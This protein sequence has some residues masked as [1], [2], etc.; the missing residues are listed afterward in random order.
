M[1][2]FKKKPSIGRC[3]WVKGEAGQT[4]LPAFGSVLWDHRSP[5][6]PDLHCLGRP[7][8]HPAARQHLFQLLR[9]V[10][11]TERESDMSD[12]GIKHQSVL[13]FQSESFEVARIF[14]EAEAR[15]VGSLLQ[16][17]SEALQTVITHRVTVSSLKHLSISYH[18]HSCMCLYAHWSAF[19]YVGDNLRQDLLPPV[20]GKCH[21]IQVRDVQ[22][23]HH[24]FKWCRLD[25]SRAN[26]HRS[27]LFKPTLS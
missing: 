10:C 25:A 11:E 22:E 17:S 20:C 26:S 2:F 23:D 12:I 6:R 8:L 14:S 19:S 5:R 15:R 21:R 27:S 9:G 3:L 24:F 16:I 7:L 4:G 1:L 13:L 18:S